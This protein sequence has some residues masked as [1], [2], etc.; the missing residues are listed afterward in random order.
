MRKNWEAGP[1]KEPGAVS[2]DWYKKVDLG[3]AEMEKHRSRGFKTD[4]R[5]KIKLYTERFV[6]VA[7]HSG[8]LESLWRKTGAMGIS[9]GATWTVS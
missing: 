7:Q 4:H 8:S 5:G 9:F 2:S 1:Q 3:I 6:H